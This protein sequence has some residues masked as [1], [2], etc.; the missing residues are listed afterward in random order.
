MLFD[1]LKIA[2][3]R[4]DENSIYFLICG[5]VCEEELSRKFKHLL[6]FTSVV[7]KLLTYAEVCGPKDFKGEARCGS[8]LL[9]SQ[10]Q[11]LRIAEIL[12]SKQNIFMEEKS[13]A[14]LPLSQLCHQCSFAR[15]R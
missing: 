7:H 5:R 4:K 12:P 13:K 8:T 9:Q 3:E 10:Y 15:E 1:M 2:A 6:I 14:I 11:R